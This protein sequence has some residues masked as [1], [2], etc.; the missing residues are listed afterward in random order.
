MPKFIF[1]TGGRLD[2]ALLKSGVIAEQDA[3][4]VS[5]VEINLVVGTS[6]KVVIHKLLDMDQV[7]ALADA[8]LESRP[9]PDS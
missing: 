3:Q 8:I 9:E 1:G 7:D 6:A 2:E 4:F 5:E